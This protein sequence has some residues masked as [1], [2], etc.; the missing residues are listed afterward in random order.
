MYLQRVAG[1]VTASG[2]RMLNENLRVLRHASTCSSSPQ[3]AITRPLCCTL[4]QLETL[5]INDPRFE[6]AFEEIVTDP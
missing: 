4:G 5:D 2:F 1:D 6:R 3:P